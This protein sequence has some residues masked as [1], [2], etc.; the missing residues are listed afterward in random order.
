M[1]DSDRAVVE[2]KVGRVR[3]DRVGVRSG[4]RVRRAPIPFARLW[5]GMG[6]SVALG[7]AHPCP[8]V[9]CAQEPACAGAYVFGRYSSRRTVNPDGSVH[10][11][12][13]E[14]PRG[15][16][17]VL[18]KGHHPGYITW[19]E[20]LAIEAKL[21]ANRTNAGERPARTLLLLAREE[22]RSGGPGES[23]PRAPADPGVTLSRHRALLVLLTRSRGSTASAR[24]ASG[25]AR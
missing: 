18:I 10:T 4:R 13:V 17:P 12:T 24:T 7:P 15:Q 5:R 20:Y 16:W 2:M 6:R 3:C 9:G 19:E 23:H 22:A 25:T 1:L 21:A 14:L 8:G 11:R